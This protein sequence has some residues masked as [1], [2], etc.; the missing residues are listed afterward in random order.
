M[1]NTHVRHAFVLL[2]AHLD[3]SLWKRKWLNGLVP[4]ETPYGYHHAE[5]YGYRVSFS[6]PM[7]LGKFRS[8]P[9]KML[10]RLT[11]LDLTHAWQHRA[12]LFSQSVDVI[13]T[14]TER[15]FLPVVLLGLLTRQRPQPMI[16]QIVWL[17][18]DWPKFSRLQQWL[19]RILLK[20]VDWC[21]CHSPDNLKFL[22][23]EMHVSNASL[24]EFGVA[25][26]LYRQDLV[27]RVAAHQPIRILVLGNDI[28]R[29]WAVLKAAFSN[30]PNIEVFIAS[31]TCPDDD[32]GNNMIRQLCDWKT[33]R[34]RYEWADVVVVPL[35]PNRHAS[36]LTVML[37]ATASGKPVVAT[38]V[39]GLSHYLDAQ[40][41]SFVPAGDAIVLRE[42]VIGLVS[43]ERLIEQR[44][45][46]A[47]E[48]FKARHFDTHGYSRR[49][50]EISDNLRSFRS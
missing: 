38:D 22:T 3:V 43:D 5:L 45:R 32:L 30:Q 47:R 48:Q 18:D 36:G 42:K 40:A 6:I 12:M 24:V 20:R 4:D 34:Q 31:S 13:W 21:T 17:A 44:V 28:H 33:V 8:W 29:D 23:E 14:H 41:V 50:V 2:P 16:G 46:S 35:S 15:E 39:G 26:E 1:S 27:V 25:S 37:E 7:A 19:Y 11:G 10:R 49:H 9:F